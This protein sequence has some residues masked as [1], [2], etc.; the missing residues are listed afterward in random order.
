MTFNSK[1]NN[2]SFLVLRMEQFR[3]KEGTWS[4]LFLSA[5]QREISD[6]DLKLF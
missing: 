3:N 6:K 4:D 1:I 5:V 2:R